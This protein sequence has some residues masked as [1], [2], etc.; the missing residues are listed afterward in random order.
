[1]DDV[2][3]YDQMVENALR[4]VVR[5]ALEETRAHGLPGQHH[6]YIT[7]R[8]GDPGVALPE[9]LRSKY[10][11]EMTIVLQHQFWDLEVDGEGF[12]VTLSFGGRQTDLAIPYAAMTSF[13]DPSVKFG[14]QFQATSEGAAPPEA[15]GEANDGDAQV[16]AEASNG[17]ADDAETAQTAEVVTLDTFRNK[18]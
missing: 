14:L 3:R 16:V 12:R 17:E 9:E 15:S 2:L 6:F 5:Q 8:T 4:D 11:Q 13:V 10:P 18:S 7:F 1:M